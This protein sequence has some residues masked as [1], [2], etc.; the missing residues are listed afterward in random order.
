MLHQPSETCAAELIISI[1]TPFHEWVCLCV[2]VCLCSVCVCVCVVCLNVSQ[3]VSTCLN[4]SG[5]VSTCAAGGG[6]EGGGGGVASGEKQLKIVFFYI[7]VSRV[8][9]GYPL[10]TIPP[11]NSTKMSVSSSAASF[12]FFFGMKL[13]RLISI[14]LISHS[15]ET[16]T[17]LLRSC[18]IEITR[19]S[20]M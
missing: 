8:R 20:T 6:G 3:R 14:W 18:R 17:I 12:L 5:S 19:L 10:P 13:Y 7:G 15:I 1:W 16:T 11:S 9:N 2:S 4:V